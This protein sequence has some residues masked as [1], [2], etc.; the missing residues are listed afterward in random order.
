[1][2]TTKALV[3]A[4]FAALSIGTAFAQQVPSGRN[5]YWGSANQRPVMNNQVQSGSSDIMRDEP[6]E[7]QTSTYILE[8]PYYGNRG[9]AG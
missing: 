1:M 9:V 8:H 7:K 5:A 2:K 6:T 4:A 3:L